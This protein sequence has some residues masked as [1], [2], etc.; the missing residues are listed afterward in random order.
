MGLR[1]LPGKYSLVWITDF[2]AMN[3]TQNK[4]TPGP[5]RTE[6]L[7]VDKRH[8]H[9][10]ILASN[11][12]AHPL[13]AHT[14]HGRGHVK[15]E[16]AVANAQLM[17]AAPDLLKVLETIANSTYG[18]A[19]LPTFRIMMSTAIAKAKGETA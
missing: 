5:W 16:E 2:S 17:A 19:M 11:S 12:S 10:A 15:Y 1:T 8:F 7:P 9:V 18:H 3:N 14:Q 4:H 13:I 6:S